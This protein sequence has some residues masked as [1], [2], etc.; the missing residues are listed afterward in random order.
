MLIHIVIRTSKFKQ[1]TVVITIFLP[2]WEGGGI[3]C[4]MC[5]AD[6]LSSVIDP[7]KVHHI[8]GTYSV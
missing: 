8:S 6:S 3:G 7:Y 2:S 4:T 5:V 1:C